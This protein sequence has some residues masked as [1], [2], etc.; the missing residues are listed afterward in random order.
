MKILDIIKQE[1]IY[2]I[3]REDDTK[4]ALELANAYIEGGIKILELNC[5]LEVCEKISK[6]EKKALD[7]TNF[8]GYNIRC[9]I[10]G[11]GELCSNCN[12][13]SYEA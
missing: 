5:P 11:V 12:R 9:C 7:K 8:R 10:F 6:K 3:I 1:K 13:R 4:C 2:G